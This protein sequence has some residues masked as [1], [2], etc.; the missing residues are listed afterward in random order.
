MVEYES[1]EAL[2]EHLT[3]ELATLAETIMWE[4][5]WDA[6]VPAIGAAAGAG[7]VMLVVNYV[8]RELAHK[9]DRKHKREQEEEGAL[10]E[11]KL[12]LGEEEDALAEMKLLLGNE[13][14]RA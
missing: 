5:F 10:A 3:I 12:L 6:A 9:Q 7:A 8:D 14:R 1:E 2:N 4:K 11:M 13:G